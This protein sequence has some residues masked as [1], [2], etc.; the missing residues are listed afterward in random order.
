MF[1]IVCFE[2]PAF[3]CGVGG[4]GNL[5]W[6]SA[7]SRCASVD[8]APPLCLRLWNLRA[9]CW[10]CLPYTQDLANVTASIRTIL[11]APFYKTVRCLTVSIFIEFSHIGGHLV[12]LLSAPKTT[13]VTLQ[14]RS[15]AL[16]LCWGYYTRS[17]ATIIL[18]TWEEEEEEVMSGH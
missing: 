12:S 14:S 2:V 11:L 6:F 10:T 16:D 15:Y 8:M 4:L 7:S 17:K 5:C 1:D 3:F 18:H 9:Q 13:K